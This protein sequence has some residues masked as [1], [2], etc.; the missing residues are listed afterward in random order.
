MYSLLRVS[1]YESRLSSIDIN[2]DHC[3]EISK[4]VSIFITKG[5]SS[6][7]REFEDLLVLGTMEVSEVS[8]TKIRLLKNAFSSVQIIIF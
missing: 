5:G 8:E 6:C 2:A 7:S 4:P 1:L 3:V